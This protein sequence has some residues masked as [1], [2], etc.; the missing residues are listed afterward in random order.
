MSLHLGPDPV[1]V[2][3]VSNHSGPVVTTVSANAVSR[4]S[5]RIELA[6]ASGK[7]IN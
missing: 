5:E 3:D 7:A 6:P 4:T 1:A 2:V